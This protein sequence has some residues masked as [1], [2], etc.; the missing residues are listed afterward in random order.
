V[1]RVVAVDELTVDSAVGWMTP[2]NR[3]VA[4]TKAA[5]TISARAMGNLPPRPP[6]A[7]GG[8]AAL[9]GG[10]ATTC[11]P[12]NPRMDKQVFPFDGPTPRGGASFGTDRSDRRMRFGTGLAPAP[13]RCGAV[14]SAD[15]L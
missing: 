13:G 3:T 2:S 4:T 11:Q 8:R 15:D 14:G 7:A 1:G 5:S 10:W 9:S 12:A 6:E